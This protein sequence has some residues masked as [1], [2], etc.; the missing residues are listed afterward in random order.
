VLW[1]DHLHKRTMAAME[2]KKLNFKAL[3]ESLGE[4]QAEQQERLETL[5]TAGQLRDIDEL[6]RMFA[7]SSEKECDESR[8]L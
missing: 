3:L 2:Q 6:K 8:L 1:R 7:L 4:W 5:L